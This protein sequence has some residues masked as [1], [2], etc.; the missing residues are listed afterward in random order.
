MRYIKKYIYLVPIVILL[1]L[2]VGFFVF[3]GDGMLVVTFL[4]VD[5]GDSILIQ[6]PSSA[7]VL[8][9]C[10]PDRSVLSELGRSVPFYDRTIDLLVITHPDADHITGCID[11]VERYRISRVLI[12]GIASTSNLWSILDDAI[13]R[14]HIPATVARAGESFMFDRAVLRVLFPLEDVSGQTFK[15]TN[16][17]SIVAMLEYGD[18]RFL[19]TGDA[20]VSVEQKLLQVGTNVSAQ[21]LKVGHHGSRTSSSREFLEKVHPAYAVIQVGEKNKYGHPTQDVL[22]RL[23]HIGAKV[24]RT[25]RDGRLEMKSDGRQVRVK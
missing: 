16:D 7:T 6:S 18:E 13:E 10:G 22:E 14:K 1:M 8:I 15:N 11:V 3:R 9:D 17:S 20:N 23:R 12:T 25:D 24:L 2:A 19:F 5:Q 4:D 21:V